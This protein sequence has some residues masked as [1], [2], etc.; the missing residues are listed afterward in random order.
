MIHYSIVPIETV[1]AGWDEMDK[2][3]LEIQGP[4]CILVVE[5]TEWGEGTLVQMISSNP[6]LYLNPAL[7]PGN[8]ISFL[9]GK[10]PRLSQ[11]V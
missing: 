6:S 8:K 4:N 11:P 5:P 1:F 3:F 7:Q 10:G 2:E 9:A